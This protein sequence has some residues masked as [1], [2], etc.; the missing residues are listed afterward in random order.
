MRTMESD[1][2]TQ[3]FKQRRK[4]LKHRCCKEKPDLV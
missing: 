2:N 3:K 4:K 1:K